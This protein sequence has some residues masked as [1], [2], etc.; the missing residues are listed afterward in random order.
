MAIRLPRDGRPELVHVRGSDHDVHGRRLPESRSARPRDSPR[1]RTSSAEQ[2][3]YLDHALASP[4]LAAQ[5][6]GADDWHINADEPIALDYNVEFKTT[7]QVN[8]FYDSGPYRASDHDPVVI[9]LALSSASDFFLPKTFNPPAVNSVKA[10]DQTK[11]QFSLGGNQ[12]L[13]VFAAGYPRRP[14]TCA[15]RRERSTRRSRRPGRA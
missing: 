3:G 10:G 15:A 6:T 7:N 9:G 12:G 4:S 13:N 14:S 2:S 1:T 8:T 11:L 5:A